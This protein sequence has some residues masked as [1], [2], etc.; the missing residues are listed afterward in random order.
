VCDGELLPADYCNKLSFKKYG[1]NNKFVALNSKIQI[2]EY[3]VFFKF[4]TL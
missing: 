3:K 4:S 1:N 2:I